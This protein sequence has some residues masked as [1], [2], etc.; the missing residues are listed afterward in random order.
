MIS[1]TYWPIHFEDLEPHRFEDLC[2]ELIYDYKEWYSIEAT[3][4]WWSD[5]WFD[6]RG[7]EKKYEIVDKEQNES[8]LDEG[9]VAQESYID[10]WNLWMI[11]CKRERSIT[12]A[13][14]KKILEDVDELNPPYWY[15]LI[16]PVDFT[17]KSYDAFTDGLRK[18]WV[19]EFYLWWKADLEH[20]LYLPKNDHI[21][22][23]FFGISLVAKKRSKATT[24]RAVVMN[25][26]KLIRMAWGWFDYYTRILLRDI[27]ASLYPYD[28]QY[29]DFDINPRRKVYDAF[30]IHPK[31]LL[32]RVHNFFAYI[33]ED[34]KTRDYMP[35]LNLLQDHQDYEKREEYF[36]TKDELEEFW[37]FLPKKNR[38]YYAIDWLV[39]YNDMI[40]ID[41][42][43]DSSFDMPHIYLDLIPKI[44]YFSWT[45]KY[46]KIGNKEVDIT[47][48]QQ[49]NYFSKLKNLPDSKLLK[50]AVNLNQMLLDYI[51]RWNIDVLYDVDWKLKFLKVGNI[52][53]IKDQE[54]LQVTH[55]YVTTVCDV[56][57]P[58]IVIQLIWKTYDECK[59][60][61]VAVYEFKRKRWWQIK[62]LIDNNT[63]NEWTN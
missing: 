49:I 54:Y 53:K 59:E 19:K 15:I 9:D 40:L 36:K 35:K 23:A 39:N 45:R 14:I 10:K 12:A 30:N 57:N 8:V 50:Q 7:Y 25:K 56:D 27:N 20:M 51:S 28:F 63:E 55:K 24:S 16:A 43:G 32:F 34:D 41:D 38:A 46:L 5:D 52:I 2:R 61:S 33:N 18:K 29:K 37:S 22:F 13:K 4:R 1:R 26:N 3:W 62:G 42:K 11:Q 60:M 58:N 47:N 48:Y 21:L 17:K 6:V 44:W 31:G